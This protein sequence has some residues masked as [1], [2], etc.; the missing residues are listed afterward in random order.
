MRKL[1][2]TDIDNYYK[3]NSKYGGWYSKNE[4]K[5]VKP[6]NKFYIVNMQDSTDGNGTHWVCIYNVRP[7][8]CFYF[9]PFGVYPPDDIVKFMK[10]TKKECLMSD[11]EIQKI[12]SQNCGWYCLFIIDKLETG[13]KYIDVLVNDFD[14]SNKE[15]NESSVES[16]FPEVEGEGIKEVIQEGWKRLKGAI[17]GVRK[18][19]G[20]PVRKFIEDHGKN[21]IVGARVC[22]TP[23][24]KSIEVLANALSLG[25][26]NKRKKELGYDNFFHL[27]IILTMRMPNGYNKQVRMEKNQVVEVKFSDE[28]NG[29]ECMSVANPNVSFKEFVENGEKLQGNT[30]WLYNGITNNCQVFVHTLLKANNLIT[31]SLERFVKQNTQ[32]LVP[33]Y[34]ENF[35]LGVTN[36]AARADQIVSGVGV[37]KNDIIEKSKPKYY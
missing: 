24:F 33:K 26:W 31:P 22:R 16:A 14:L 19:A 9:D 2:S 21:M 32:D 28:D 1:T 12:D 18:N 4:L 5:T 10:K 27:F 34:V 11:M 23:I 30:F 7:K 35:M 6:A 25:Q 15:D 36:T 29:G 20:P 17:S 3:G 8:S 13:R 37:K